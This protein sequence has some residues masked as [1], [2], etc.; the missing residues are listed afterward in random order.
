MPQTSAEPK[1]EINEGGAR[2]V[3]SFEKIFKTKLADP[4]EAMNTM[5]PPATSNASNTKEATLPQIK[6]QPT[7]PATNTSHKRDEQPTTSNNKTKPSVKYVDSVEDDVFASN[8]PKAK[9]EEKYSDTS[10]DDAD[11]IV[12][13]TR[14]ITSSDYFDLDDLLR[15]TVEKKATDL[16]LTANTPPIYRHLGE[17]MPIPG[18]PPLT[19]QA[20]GELIY[21]ILSPAARETF[22]REQEL[23]I[24]Y[25][26]KHV[27][28]F[29]VNVYQQ[30]GTI[31]AAIRLIPS[32][33]PGFDT[34]NLPP[35]ISD[36]ADFPRGLVL[37]TGP[38]GS[39]KSTTLAAI[40]DK[41]NAN[42]KRHI[43][44][45]EDPVEFVH[46]NK[47]CII[48]QREVGNDTKSFNEALRNALRQDPDVIM[49]GEMRDLETIK[50]AL[51]AAETGHLVFAT[52]HTQS[53]SET[54]AR[55]I[56]VFPEGSKD[57]VRAQLAATIQGIACQSLIKKI[58]KQGMIAAVEIL[59][60]TPAI[61]ALIRK[62][63]DEQ[64]ITILETSKQMGMQTM[65]SHLI[66]LVKNNIIEVDAAMEKAILPDNIIRGLGGKE[67]VEKAKRQQARMGGVEIK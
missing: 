16:H 15:F 6:T 18:Y 57:Q 14:D 45:I 23:N 32:E 33:I 25:G 9:K 7:Q 21:S 56:D 4:S 53:V 30:R 65:D 51:T 49:L 1:T 26:I 13:T 36:F 24:S 48:N 40:I 61:R 54:M 42:K 41:I 64:I 37:I 31:S 55:I 8:K 50:S 52:L 12:V 58:D 44:T 3:T 47:K 39:G 29:R 60:A 62:G 20:V 38:T 43:L 59:K 35:A 17:I 67:G 22:E 28:R 46:K 63:S 5:A 2:E 27:G 11:S 34:L 10:F 66:E 19:A